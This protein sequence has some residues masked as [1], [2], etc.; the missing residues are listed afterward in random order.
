ME[1]LIINQFNEAIGDSAHAGFGLMRCV[2]IEAF[3][4]AVKVKNAPSSLFVTAF[5]GNFTADAG[6]NI[7]TFTSGGFNTPLTGTAVVLTTTT[8]LPAGLS[9]STIYYV[10]RIDDTTFKLAST[11][12][13]ANAGTAIDITDAGTGTHTATSINPGTI[14][15]IAYNPRNEV[16]FLQDSNAR[17]WYLGAGS[18]RALLLNGNTLTN[19]VGNGLGFLANSDGTAE[20]LFVFRNASID[21]INVFA[22]TNLETP[23]WS[24]SWKSLNSTAGSGYRHHTIYGQDSI[25]YFTDAKYVGSIRE[26]SGQVF[27]PSSAPTYTYNNQALDTPQIE[28]LVH[29]EELGTNL[30]ASSSTSN[31]IY[32]W[33]RISDSFTLPINVPEMNVARMKNI[34]NLVYILA[35]RKGVI[36]QTQGS[37]VRIAKKLPDQ[38]INNSGTLQSNIV[39]W[40]GIDSIGGALL[41]GAGVLTSGNSGAYKLYPDGR[42]V[43]DQLPS[44]GSANV[45]AFHVIN[46]FYHFGYASG[47]D[48]HSSSRYSSFQGVVNSA[49]Y[50]V[51]TKTGKAN[52]SV[53]EVVIAKPATS[54]NVRVSYRT[55]T[56]SAFTT[57][58]TFTADSTNTTFKND[59]I[60]LI[61]IENIQVQAEI[62]GTMELVEI[63][64]LK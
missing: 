4:G 51:A 41:F 30:L 19:G 46:D 33:D 43:I 34:G 40:G 5:A 22:T 23:S 57:I 20:Y 3:P 2:D 56:S 13:L 36:Y 25:I 48:E 50:R 31:K 26:N 12:A 18:T 55:D 59:G 1:N 10:I 62:D 27:D 9:L 42:L 24:N 8:T 11:I 60:G 21:V 64:L 44:A 6:S 38:V 49:F 16:R 37:Y 7:C 63:R 28:V 29:L 35:G 53:M 32:P 54:G 52:Y 15:H 47:A 39:T 58:D 61:D 45:T 17:V 14:N